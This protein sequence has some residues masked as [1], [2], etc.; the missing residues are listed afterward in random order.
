[1]TIFN[2][3][4]CKCR[5]PVCE[6]STSK[7][8]IRATFSGFSTTAPGCAECDR[9]DEYTLIL[10]RA[11]FEEPAATATAIQASDIGVCQGATFDVKLDQNANG[12]FKVESI[13]VVNGGS[14]Y[15][16]CA[17]VQL[18]FTNGIVCEEPLLKV[19]TAPSESPPTLSAT[20]DP[21]PSEEWWYG[22]VNASIEV[23]TEQVDDTHWKVAP[24]TVTNPGY[25]YESPPQ[26]KITATAGREVT[27]A[28][29]TAVLEDGYVTSV[30]LNDPGSFTTLQKISEVEVVRGGKIH[31][32]MPC[33]YDSIYCGTCPIT[34]AGLYWEQGIDQMRYAARVTFLSG[35]EVLFQAYQW[36]ELQFSSVPTGTPNPNMFSDVWIEAKITDW[37]GQFPITF[38][39]ESFY[40]T[41]GCTTVGS[42]AIDKASC[43]EQT[44][45]E[46]CG[47]VPD[48]ITLKLENFD[49]LMGNVGITTCPDGS[50]H[51]AQN[52]TCG[53]SLFEETRPIYSQP[54]GNCSPDMP[55]STTGDC[56]IRTYAGSD[57]VASSIYGSLVNGDYVLDLVHPA[58][59]RPLASA[60]DLHC[61][62]YVYA[63]HVD[64]APL[65]GNTWYPPYAAGIYC[66]VPS[67]EATV[68]VRPVN[69]QPA[70]SLDSPQLP[71]PPSC[72]GPAWDGPC[73]RATG[74]VAGIGPN[75]EITGINVV[76]SGRCYAWRT[77]TNRMPDDED[78][79]FSVEASSGTGAEFQA[80]WEDTQ[81]LGPDAGQYRVDE[82]TVTDGGTGY[83]EGQKI[84]ATV[85]PVVGTDVCQHL[86]FEGRV[87]AQHLEPEV[88]ATVPSI[89]GSGA[90]LEIVWKEVEVSSGG[91][92][93]T[94]WEIDS[95]TVVEGGEKYAAA[96]SVQLAMLPGT[97]R[98]GPSS[99]Y[100]VVTR[101]VPSASL[102]ASMPPVS[103][104][105]AT[106]SVTLSQVS[107]HWVVQSVSVDWPGYGYEQGDEVVFNLQVGEYEIAPMATVSVNQCGSITG[108][109]VVNQGKIVVSGDPPPAAPAVTADM[110]PG[111][112]AVLSVTLTPI[113]DYWVVQ[114]VNVD[115][116]GSG[117]QQGAAV[118]FELQEGQ[119]VTAPQATVSVDQYGSI[120]G[121]TIVNQGKIVSKLG[122]ISAVAVAPWVGDVNKRFYK[123]TG[124]IE[125]VRIV[126]DGRFRVADETGVDYR[127]PDV[128]ISTRCYP[129]RAA[130]AVAQ[131][132]L[133]PDSP[134][135]GRVLSI[136]LTDGGEGY[137][138]QLIGWE[139][140]ISWTMSSGYSVSHRTFDSLAAA[141][142][143]IGD[144]KCPVSL[145][146]DDAGSRV[147]VG[148]PQEL[149]S[150]T[151]RMMYFSIWAGGTIPVDCPGGKY[152][153][154]TDDVGFRYY[155]FVEG[156]NGDFKCT[157]APA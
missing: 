42:V 47:P 41:V 95:V 14:C 155:T 107:D 148:C 90:E 58:N 56:H 40:K 88:N 61:D 140:T 135:F 147:T 126:H 106:L 128:Y 77:Y 62:E 137:S 46:Q 93:S 75:G 74:A 79:T 81:G 22:D 91:C 60:L 108:V 24:I 121:V 157:L 117:Y 67:A 143:E 141:G 153:F 10:R 59:K 99:P 134:T 7:G 70:V 2:C 156:P 35:T 26:I 84:V 138:N 66:S 144:T 82:L 80:L 12:V 63:G 152:C 97:R 43:D 122:S 123:D 73:E 83:S 17:P 94:L 15:S 9:L 92:T 50:P 112:P 44:V 49:L 57:S 31:P 98:Y 145:G 119:Y 16:D 65:I 68:R 132:D 142:Y 125:C 20:I 13:D 76:S 5:C 78:V 1:M 110:P 103:A 11:E 55:N 19:K 150:K 139:A 130:T 4:S 154:T 129:Q 124:I 38:P 111:G 23:T 48:Q 39:P 114:S 113:S 105:S 30:T 120:T 36:D 133:D 6:Y 85:H 115:C 118:I 3:Q 151:Y 34:R 89:T 27:P 18:Y 116:P 8:C 149:L 86:S 28:I 104:G 131:L 45:S 136:D 37:D 52:W 51:T 64:V 96:D 32:L 101:D 146:L 29:A 127:V 54:W 100:F 87:V 25:G 21:S 69:C 71:L 109:T 102:S 33:V 53:E 72:G